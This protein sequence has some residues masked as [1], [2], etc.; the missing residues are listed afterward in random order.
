MRNLV[1]LCVLGLAN[2]TGR[3]QITVRGTV[4]DGR[5]EK[6]VPGLNVL[7]QDLRA[8]A[9]Y[10]Y[11]TTGV[12]G[13]YSVTYQ[14]TDDSLLLAITGFN[15][16]AVKRKISARNQIL[17]IRVEYQ[18]VTIN[19]VKVKAEPIR[20]Q[21]DTLNYNV[22]SFSDATDRSIGNVLKKMPGIEVEKSGKIKYNGKPINKFY[23]EG[24]DMLEG[25]YGIATHN[26][27][28]K[29]ISTVQVFENHQ[30]VRVLKDLRLSDQAALNLKLK[31]SAKN[32]FNALLHLGGGYKPGLWNGELIT[33]YFARRLQSLNTYKT[34]NTGENVSEELRSFYDKSDIFISPLQ[35]HSPIKPPLEQER[36]LKN[37]IHSISVNSLRKLKSDLE[38]TAHVDYTHDRQSERG[39]SVTTHYLPDISPLVL[40]EQT[41]V[42]RSTD[43][44]RASL[45]FRTNTE[46]KY[47]EEKFTFNGKW[48][49]E[50]GDV[51]LFSD[52]VIQKFHL[53]RIVLRNNLDHM[54]QYGRKI[55][56][57]HSVIDYSDQPASLRITPFL[58]PE[59]F[60]SRP[61]YR[62][63][64]QMMNERRLH[65]R[66]WTSF[67]FISRFWNVECKAEINAYF[68]WMNSSLNPLDGN[69]RPFPTDDSMQNRIY[70]Q[71]LEMTLG[72]QVTY[73][74][75]QT[76]SL[77]LYIPFR[78]LNLY[79]N[80]KIRTQ[81]ERLNKILVTPVFLLTTDLN[82]RFKLGINASY[83][84]IIGGL[85]DIYSGY[86]L[87][88]YRIISSKEG[89]IS[90]MDLQNYSLSLEYR[91][92]LAGIFGFLNTRYWRTRS[93]LMYGTEYDG[94][95]SRIETYNRSNRAHGY[96]ADIRL[97]KRFTSLSTTLS[98]AGSYSR[99][100]RELLRQG[101]IMKT[102]DE[103]TDAELTLYT[104]F[105]PS[106]LFSYTGNYNRIQSRIQDENGTLPAI[107]RLQQ[108]ATLDLI[109][110]EKYIFQIAGEHYYNDA[111]PAG[112]RKMFFLD[113]FFHYRPGKTEYSI[114]ARNLLNTNTFRSV[115]SND[116]IRYA[117]TYR[118]RPC[119]VLLKIKFSL[120]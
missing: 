54:K 41:S 89:K 29:D 71:K 96:T 60:G 106:L 8:K 82:P 57:L 107:N 32:T 40:P 103:N 14:G 23:I 13:S 45:L 25:R 86:I 63:V 94:T 77:S 10:D 116:L 21:R 20:K 111:I 76:L 102:S 66:N 59:I 100:F 67:G 55:L 95:L 109:F 2:L 56:S 91:N 22:A 28:A 43:Q 92:I 61:H 114:E 87:T 30:P 70:R 73:K 51:F 7:L 39:N 24:L 11:T 52:S 74:P 97:A 4:V 42:F 69:G 46:K 85:N 16:K 99:S 38:M 62:N 93:N 50:K 34:N 118:L 27:L 18:R 26:I 115:S 108:N 117:Y 119:S 68:E 83:F 37:N 47:L 58:Y 88:D 3:A 33:L 120:K 98:V 79:V 5:T 44:A 53:P 75:R 15:I 48:D 84:P 101:E 78:F 65:T 1:I 6:A 19:E 17:S 72:P 36:Y 35:V 113:A 81:R 112:N 105:T 104:R 90:R 64:R 9:I 12:D 49:R 31:K 80:D 110:R